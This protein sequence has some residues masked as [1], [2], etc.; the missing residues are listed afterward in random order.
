MFIYKIT[1]VPTNQVYIG[2]DTKP[3]YKESRWK[4]HCRDANK[5]SRRKVH[6]IMG[7]VGLENCRYEVISRGYTKLS[8]LAIAEI[9]CIKEHDSYKKGLNSSPGGDGI[10]KH[11]LRTMSDSELK[12][13]RESLGEHWSEYNKKKWS[14]MSIEKKLDAMSHLHNAEVYK[15]RTDTL[16]KYY[17]NVLGAKKAKGISIKKWQEE[18]KEILKQNNRRSGMIGALKVSKAV[19]IEDI[20]GNV[21]TFYS[22]SEF[23]RKTG[24]WFATLVAKSARGEYYNNYRLRKNNSE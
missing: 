19:T 16:K 7:E 20:A 6:R 11:D 2:L 1:I 17:E 13:I 3:E 23:Q 12:I 10:G 4:A 8:E 5:E 15:K 18:N 21:E 14:G 22:R 24:L 9:Q